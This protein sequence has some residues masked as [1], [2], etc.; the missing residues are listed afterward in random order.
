MPL[1]VLVRLV[2]GRYDAGGP[3]PDEAEWPPHPARVFCA[4]TASGPDEAE[5]AALRW[6]ERLHAPQVWASDAVAAGRSGYVVTNVRH[7]GPGGFS[8]TWPGR[9]NGVRKRTG[10][11]PGYG[12]FA[13]AWP[14]AGPDAGCLAALRRL[15]RRVPYVGRSTSPA[16]V[17]VQAS[18]PRDEP[19]WLHWREAETAGRGTA[20]LRV[21]YRG[22]SD[23]LDA[24]FAEGRRAWEVPGRA[25]PYTAGSEEP[26]ESA[27]DQIAG[28][29]GELLVFGFERGAAMLHGRSLLTMTGTLR[30]AVMDRIGTGVPAPVTGHGADDRAHI[31]YLALPDAGHQHAD[32]HLLG[33]ALAL[34]AD[35]DDTEL[36][37]ILA[38]VI[39]DPL[40]RLRIRGGYEA[41]V[42][43]EPLRGSPWGLLPERWT[44]AGQGGSRYWATA[45]P[46]MLDRHPHRAATEMSE[47]AWSL[48]RAGYPEPKDVEVSPAALLPGAVHRLDLTAIPVRKPPRPMLHARVTFPSRVTGPVVAGALKYLGAGLFAPL[49]DRP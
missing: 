7:P 34:P 31:A 29:F 27:A 26:S 12:G 48:A 38:R 14:D 5:R 16:V 47:V 44:A 30:R 19:G 46:M 42:S 39:D 45:T 10:V 28:P 35:L 18:L 25:V 17:S 22:Y 3:R 43:Y 32:G 4:L 13:L 2:N 24:A 8:Q 33:V 23:E 20:E 15:A 37:A 11:V 21:P 6:V 36:A 9:T 1:T 40:R 49:P 41:G